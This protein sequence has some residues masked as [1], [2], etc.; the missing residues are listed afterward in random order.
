LEEK[1]TTVLLG[2][3]LEKLGDGEIAE[4]EKHPSDIGIL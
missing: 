3:Y 2:P 1:P 4:G